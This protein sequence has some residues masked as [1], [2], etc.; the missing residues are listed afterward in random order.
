MAPKSKKKTKTGLSKKEEELKKV[1]EVMDGLG[2]AEYMDYMSSPKRV[3]WTNLLAGIMRGL[4]FVL[5]MTVVV[6][7]I[8]FIV[9]YMVAIPV[10]GEWFLWLKEILTN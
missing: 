3:I 5:G 9:S 8:T 1:E 7:L 2:L 6:A 4:G 10:I